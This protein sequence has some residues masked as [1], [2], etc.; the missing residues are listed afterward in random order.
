MKNRRGEERLIHIHTKN[1]KVESSEER[2][3]FL[4]RKLIK[5]PKKK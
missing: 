1:K 4:N 3:G 2:E 5:L